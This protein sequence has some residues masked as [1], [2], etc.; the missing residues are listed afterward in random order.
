VILGTTPPVSVVDG[1]SG[2]V[3]G[4]NAVIAAYGAIHNIPVIDYADAMC[5]CAS[6]STDWF[7]LLSTNGMLT[8]PVPPVLPGQV[9]LPSTAGYALMTQLAESVV[10]TMNLKLVTGWLSNVVLPDAE[11]GG[12]QINVNTVGPPEIVQF[13]AIGYYSDGSQH[14]MLNTNMQY[15]TGTWTSSNPTV[16]YINQQGLAWALSGGTTSIKYIPLSEA[17]FSEWVMNV[18]APV[19]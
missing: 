9:Q 2:Y 5:G 14:P 3:A 13:T 8:P 7:P 17:A 4:I 1:N 15:A 16:M 12:G 19:E 10:N 11:S 18:S 6:L